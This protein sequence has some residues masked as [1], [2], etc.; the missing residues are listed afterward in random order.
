M[1]IL[2]VETSCDDTSVAL[3]KGEEV[4]A[5]EISSQIE[6]HSQFGG[7]VPEIASREH[8]RNIDPVLNEVLKKS[9]VSL[10]EIDLF[11]ATFAPGLIGSLL[12]GLNFA[13]S[14]AYYFKKPFIGI[15]HLEGH[16]FAPFIENSDIEFPVLSL[17]VSGGHTSIYFSEKPLKYELLCSTRDDAAGEAFDKI[18]KLL[19]LGY[20][21][22]PLIDRIYNEYEDI[23]PVKFS[24]PKISDGS[25]AFSFSGLKTKFLHQ[26]R[27]LEKNEIKEKS[28]IA[29]VRGA[30]EGIVNQLLKYLEIFAGEKNPKT[31]TLSGGVA[32]NSLLRK[33]VM[34]RFGGSYKVRI[35]SPFYSTD[36]GAMIG[37]AAYVRFK[38]DFSS[39]LS[40]NAKS[41]MNL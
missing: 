21:G 35:P 26:F 13:K 37:Y 32:C 30:Q 14:L 28:V 16:F 5:C 15:N 41:S 38:N 9:N 3:L 22:G 24:M 10:D 8:L 6:I 2:S 4:L 12:V 33:R 20:P 1:Y 11:A 23:E 18:S 40:L 17:I 36:N 34:E 31:I 29:L 19:G 25:R 39:P 7:V 27:K